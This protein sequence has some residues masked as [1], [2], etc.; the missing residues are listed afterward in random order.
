MSAI[1]PAPCPHCGAPVPPTEPSAPFCCGGCRA[2]RQFLDGAGLGRYYEL[3]DQSGAP[4]PSV[5]SAEPRSFTWLEP[6]LVAARPCDGI[7]RLELDIQGIQCAAC[8]WLLSQLFR[9]SPGA[10]DID[11]NPTRGRMVLRYRE[12]QLHVRDYLADIARL[13]Y[14]TGPPSRAREGRDDLLLRFGITSAIAMN[15]MIF[16]ISTYLGLSPAND[17]GIYHVFG[18]ANWVLSILAVLIGGSVFIRGAIF[19]ASKGVLHLDAPIALGI[20]LAFLGSTWS[21]F[22][23]NG[24]AAYFDTLQV[25]IALMLLG[26]MIQHRLVDRNRRLV[27]EDAGIGDLLVRRL[28]ADGRMR[29]M[30]AV[31][32][33]GGEVLLIAPGEVAPLAG[34]LLDA[35]AELALDWMNGEPEPRPFT[36][37]DEI[38]AGAR[39]GGRRAVRI[40]AVEAFAQSRLKELLASARVDDDRGSWGPFW[41]RLARVYVLAVLALAALTAWVWWPAGPTRALEVVVA[42]LVVTCPCALGL[43]TPLAMELSLARMRRRGLFVRRLSFLDRALRV[44]KVV[45]DKTGTLTLG[46][47]ELEHPEVLEGLPGPA[48]SALAHLASRSNHPRSQALVTA[49]ED[50]HLRPSPLDPGLVVEEH[51][52]RGLEMVWENAQWRLGSAPFALCDDT[53]GVGEEL[54]L[55][56]AG[57]EVGRFHLREALRGDAQAEVRRLVDQGI[58]VHLLSGDR[59][60]RVEAF[61][62]ALGIPRERTRAEASPE[63]KAAYIQQIN[64]DDTLMV[65]DGINDAKA[66]EAAFCAGT[67][68]VDRPTLP[69]RADFFY[70]GRG[71]GAIAQALDLARQTRR[72]VYRNLALA[73]AYNVLTVGLAMA[74]FMSPLWCAIAMPLS[75]VGILIATVRSLREERPPMAAVEAPLRTFIPASAAE[76]AR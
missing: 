65:G 17:A 30:S 9:R 74:G 57:V 44:R 7:V 21:F 43:A 18:W 33:R 8:V 2:A 1:H 37:G 14:L 42:V 20:V 35:D 58:E 19:A 45:F 39:N 50:Q 3:R 61:A 46:E 40:Q 48:L 60:A 59:A 15:G 34:T 68:A 32:L 11:I 13:G 47:L 71:V 75:S 76:G 23:T 41:D 63:D 73:G 6:L 24:S 22:A 67:P 51:A 5:A 66:F 12:G 31:H 29:V 55:T 28:D 26:R 4:P 69:A 72:V 25:F 36:E 38:P 54:L 27:L 52:G 64:R 62:Q 70:L 49:I 56:R 53:Q 10:V 16:S